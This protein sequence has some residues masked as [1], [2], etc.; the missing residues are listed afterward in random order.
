MNNSSDL[1]I[2]IICKK[3]VSRWIPHLL[4]EEQ[5]HL[6]SIDVKK[7]YIDLTQEN[8]V[9]SVVMNS[10]YTVMNPKINVNLLFGCSEMNQNRRN[11]FLSQKWLMQQQFFCNIKELLVLIS[12]YIFVCRKFLEINLRKASPQQRMILHQGQIPI[13]LEKQ[14]SEQ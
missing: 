2:I 12:T 8:T 14:L 10:G 13:Q 11:F 6:G 1:Q 7:L 4:A 5:E 9:L 3:L